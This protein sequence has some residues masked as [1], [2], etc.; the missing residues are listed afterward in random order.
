MRRNTFPLLVVFLVVSNLVLAVLLFLAGGRLRRPVAEP[1][2]EFLIRELAF[3]DDQ[4]RE[5]SR[6]VDEHRR[7]ETPLIER[8]QDARLRLFG[9]L[10]DGSVPESA[11]RDAANEIGRIQGEMDLEIYHHFAQIWRMCDARQRQ[12]FAELVEHGVRAG[13][14]PPG[15]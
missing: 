5:F 6:L 14:G 4:K 11:L 2:P 13:P 1:G 7:T 8:M 3:R 10:H 9:Y 12:R 15:R